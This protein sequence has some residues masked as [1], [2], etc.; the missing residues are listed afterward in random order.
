MVPLLLVS[1]IALVV[2]AIVCVVIGVVVVRMRG[3]SVAGVLAL[4]PAAALGLNPA[5]NLESAQQIRAGMSLEEIQSR[6]GPGKLATAA[7]LN[8]AR[9]GFPVERHDGT[10]KM[11][12]A[13]EEEL[14]RAG[15]MSLYRW[16]NGDLSVFVG[17]GRGRRSGKLYVMRTF[18]VE[19][20]RAAPGGSWGYRQRGLVSTWSND[21][22]DDV[23]RL[24]AEQQKL[25]ADPKWNRGNPRELLIGRWGMGGPIGGDAHYVFG[26]DGSLIASMWFR[27]YQSTYRFLDA[28]HVEINEPVLA[29]QL[30]NPENVI[31]EPMRYRVLVSR[32]ELV[33]VDEASGTVFQYRRM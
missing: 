5:V 21:D 20:F 16:Q 26:A 12:E 4:S 25:L 17:F 29:P 2:V 30:N 32:T 8:D 18:W 23:A 33:L 19:R 22:P 1:G 11:Q 6:F 31:L 9:G 24:L 3:G 13:D 27:N 15:Q 10:G 7:D 14:I 28:N